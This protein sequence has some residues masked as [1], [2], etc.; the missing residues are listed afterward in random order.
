MDKSTYVA[1]RL[2]LSIVEQPR[3][4]GS[5]SH[6]RQNPTATR[7]VAATAS[8]GRGI[9]YNWRWMLPGFNERQRILALRRLRFESPVASSRWLPVVGFVGA[10]AIYVGI[11]GELAI[12]SASLL[13]SFAGFGIHAL[14]NRRIRRAMKTIAA[15]P[16]ACGQ[17]GY[18]LHGLDSPNC[19]ECGA[20]T[21][22]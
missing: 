4:G 20:A 22:M 12:L 16:S 19:P 21:G 14:Q 8:L 15:D 13:A 18:P 11:Y 1:S 5:R 7:R 9:S 2:K 17:C 3:P 6:V 10:F